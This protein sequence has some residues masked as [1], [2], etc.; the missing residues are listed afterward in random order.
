MTM[1][2]AQRMRNL[3][4][5]LPCASLVRGRE[6]VE[7]LGR[8]EP[9]DAE[10]AVATLRTALYDEDWLVRAGAAVS[11]R[12]V[13][14]VALH[15]A[16]FLVKAL[17]ASSGDARA[18]AAHALAPSERPRLISCRR[19]TSATV[20]AGS[21]SSARIR[22]F[23]SGRQRRRRSTPV[24]ISI[25]APVLTGAHKSARTNTGQGQPRRGRRCSPDGYEARRAASR[26]HRACASP[27]FCEC[28]GRSR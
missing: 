18:A 28:F 10:V 25:H 2:N 26:D 27:Q 1:P 6:I 5:E 9:A 3:A 12:A 15:I 16:P 21:S 24:M 13:A 17:S 11:L 7:G 14:V 19:A 8:V 23:C 22:N 20:V 4:S